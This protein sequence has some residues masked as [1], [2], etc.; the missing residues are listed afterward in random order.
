VLGSEKK[1]EESMKL[2]EVTVGELKSAGILCH[3]DW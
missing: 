1:K 3:V 2:K